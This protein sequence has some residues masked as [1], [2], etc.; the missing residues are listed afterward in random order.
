MK[1]MITIQ[2]DT[3]H[4]QAEIAAL[5]PQEQAYVQ[6]LVNNG[7]I[8]SLHISANFSVIWLVLKGES[9]EQIQQE[10]STFPIYPYMKPDFA[11]LAEIEIRPR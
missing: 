5:M 7:T 1:A 4:H 11:P 9:Q 3:Q 2:L 8:E 10:L 6:A